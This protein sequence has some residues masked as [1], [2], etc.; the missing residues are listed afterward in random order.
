MIEIAVKNLKKYYGANL[1]FENISFEIKTGE[2]VGL[3]GPNGVGKTTIFRIITN[4][5]NTEGEIFKRKELKLGYLEQIPLYNNQQKGL[6]VLYSAFENLLN[7]RKKMRECEVKL[8]S[9]IEDYEKTIQIY[10]ELQQDYERLDGYRIDEKIHRITKGINLDDLLD[11][12]FNLLSGGEQTKI[13]LGR[14]LLMEPDVMLLDEPTNH[15]DMKSIEWLENYLK[16]YEGAVLIISHDRYFLDNVVNKL[17]EINSNG[18]DVYFG[19]YSYYVVEKERRFYE[20]MKWYGNQ[21]NKI[22]RM[23]EQIHRY[24]VWGEMRDSDKMY[25]K[26]KEL[27]KRLEKMD[28]LKKPI[29]EKRKVYLSGLDGGRTGKIAVA[30]DNVSKKFDNKLI[31]SDISFELYFGDSFALLGDNGSG[32]TTLLKLINDELL[33]DKGEVKLGSRVMLGYLPQIVEFEDEE[34]SIIDL[35]VN[36][37][38]IT[39]SDARKELAKVLFFGED[40]FKKIRVLSGGEKSRLKLSMILYK[41]ANLLILDEP[42]NH[43]DI[44]SREILEEALLEFNGTLLFVSHDRYFINK[45]ASRI[46]EIIDNKMKIYDG[47]YEYYINSKEKNEIVINQNEYKAKKATKIINDNLVNDEKM[48]HKKMLIKKINEIEFRVKECE[49]KIDN[50]TFEMSINPTDYKKLEM[51]QSEKDMIENIYLDNLSELEILENKIRELAE[52]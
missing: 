6:D 38:E 28:K 8:S 30:V 40:V 19:N 10:G 9:K 22:K 45:L 50:I 31:I 51:L 3:I 18:T 41:K 13:I 47:D 42:T 37:L 35:F 43:L 48:K 2:K 46:G 29:L 5:E 14:V 4:N 36:N 16:E 7:I 44:D 11:K 24:R 1:I 21:Q 17:I 34:I 12:E 25:K 15:L 39:V 20:A 32:K 33:P 26:A 23:E 27:E 49:D 52:E